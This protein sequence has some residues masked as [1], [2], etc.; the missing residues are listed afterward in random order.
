MSKIAVMTDTNCGILPSDAEK[1]GIYMLQMPFIADGE[2]F[3]EYGS[4]EYGEFFARLAAG[5]QVSTSQPSPAALCEMWD[6]ILQSHDFVIYLPMSSGLSGTCATATAL[7]AE[8]DGRVL[9]VDNKRISVTLKSSVLDALYLRDMGLSA[10][11]I[12]ATLEKDG[13]NASIYIMVNT[14]E[15]LKKSGRVTAAGAAI[16][17]ILGIK[18]VLQ[19]QGEKLDAFKKVRGVNAAKETIFKAIRDDLDNRFSGKNLHIRFAFSGSDTQAE[20]WRAEASLHFPEYEIGMD[21]LPVSISCHVG[22]GA[23]G[24]GIYETPREKVF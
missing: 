11:E 13:L 7:A 15:F 16:G 17:S 1:Y 19:I 2:E 12:K 18:P 9:V 10:E 24:V 4:M 23:I 21:A 3:F 8:Y 20:E 22:P 14:L 6:S 5:A